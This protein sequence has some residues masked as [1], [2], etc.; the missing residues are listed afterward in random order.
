MHLEAA[1]I[2]LMRMMRFVSI[3]VSNWMHLEDEAALIDQEKIAGFNP[4]F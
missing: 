4:S 2:H 3:L 1:I